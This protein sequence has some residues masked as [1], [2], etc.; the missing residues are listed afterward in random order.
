M[1]PRSASIMRQL[2]TLDCRLKPDA[3]RNGTSLRMLDVNRGFSRRGLRT[4]YLA[5]FRSAEHVRYQYSIN[6]PPRAVES[7]AIV[8]VAI[9]GADSFAAAKV[10]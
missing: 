2:L 3:G 1:K 8:S 9:I 10:A 6:H 5:R 7:V 4:A